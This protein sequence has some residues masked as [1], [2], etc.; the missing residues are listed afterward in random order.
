MRFLILNAV[1]I[2]AT[3][4]TTGCDIEEFAASSS[5]YK[6]DFQ[7]SYNLPP[8]GRF[9]IENMNGSIEITGWDQNKVEITGTKYAATEDLLKALKIDVQADSGSVRIRT[10]RPGERHGNYGA[11]YVIRVPVKTE[12]ERVDSTNGSIRIENIEG[13]GRIGTTNG[14]LRTARYKGDLDARTTN[15]GVDVSDVTGPVTVR[16]T[17]GTIKLDSIRGDVDASTSN[18]RIEARLAGTDGN[19]PM[20][21]QTSNGSIN[22]SVDA[23]R[24]S[25]IRASTTNGGITV[26]LPANA[27]ARVQARTSNSSISTDFDVTMRGTQD[28][29]RLEGT[30]GPGGPLLDLSTTNGSIKISKM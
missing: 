5:R 26:R 23:L 16:T 13:R 18:G 10:V 9:S 14:S 19:R 15:G 20:R 28:K 12:L 1:L 11:K 7:Y 24:S 21:F 25:D 22:V 2:S 29:H 6:E 8:G 30:I 3:L 17:N 4:A 27:G